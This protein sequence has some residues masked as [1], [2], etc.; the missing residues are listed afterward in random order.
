MSGKISINVTSIKHRISNIYSDFDGESSRWLLRA[1]AAV[2][3]FPL[4]GQ[5][6]NQD[7]RT[8]SLLDDGASM[9]CNPIDTFARLKRYGSQVDIFIESSIDLREHFD[10]HQRHTNCIESKSIVYII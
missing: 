9:Q 1:T 8:A 2:K 7:A 5:S 6:F 10:H 3:R 4:L